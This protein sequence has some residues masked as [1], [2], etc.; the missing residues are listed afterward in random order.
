FLDRRP[1]GAPFFLAVGFRDVH[2]PYQ[3]ETV[4]QPHDPGGAVL[5]P[6]LPDTPEVR[7]DLARYYDEI[8]RLDASV[9]TI[10][11]ELQRR[12]LDRNTVVLFFSDNGAPF[13]R[14]KT[15]L[16]DVGIGTPLLLR[17]PG[18]VAP[19]ATTDA[20]VSLVD[21]VPTML[22]L[23]GAEAPAGLHGQ[24]FL[25]ILTNPSVAGR[26]YVFAE[27]NWHDFDDHARAVRTRRYKYIRNYFPERPFDHPADTI[28][29]PTF[30][31]MLRL[32]DAGRLTG[33]PALIFRSTR[34]REELYDLEADPYE[35]H[36]LVGTPD[37]RETLSRLSGVLERW[38]RETED[39]D[40][41]K[42]KPD[43]FDRRTGRRLPVAE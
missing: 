31:A 35:F 11:S 28:R 43:A 36:N 1:A 17:W 12:G 18:V 33:E 10:L 32:R 41:K 25:P 19:G 7:A 2:R 22:A 37:H 42:S 30:Q 15:S 5:P 14:A 20:L 24:S 13:P 4:P 6:F 38:E 26:Q 29:S 21:L 8:A 34:P 27:R 9:G 39:V 23:A 3:E 16:Y 40:P